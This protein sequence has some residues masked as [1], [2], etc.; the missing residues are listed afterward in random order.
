[1]AKKVYNRMLNGAYK[2]SIGSPRKKK[3]KK[4][5]GKSLFTFLKS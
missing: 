1:V 5:V 2:I 4:F 3:M